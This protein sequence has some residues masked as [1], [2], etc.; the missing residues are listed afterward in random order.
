M[1]NNDKLC[2]TVVE[3]ATLLGISRNTAYEMI[4]LNQLPAIR[5]GQRRLVVPKAALMNLLQAVNQGNE[6]RNE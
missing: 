4:R 3:T 6:K 1:D 5:C 2:L